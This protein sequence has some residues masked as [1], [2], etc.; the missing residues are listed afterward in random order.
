ME[1]LASRRVKIAAFTF[2]KTSLHLRHCRGPGRLLASSGKCLYNRGGPGPLFSRG[3]H[4][5]WAAAWADGSAW[6]GAH[7]SS[8]ADSMAAPE[9]WPETPDV[10]LPA[11]RKTLIPLQRAELKLPSLLSPDNKLMSPQS[12]G[13]RRSRKTPTN[14]LH[15]R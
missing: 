4:K 7:P 3:T 1:W 13:K 8:G 14:T 9:S 10:F 12:Q 6:P 2:P 15:L 11:D 5:P